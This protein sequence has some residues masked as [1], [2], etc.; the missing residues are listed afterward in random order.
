MAALTA[1][2]DFVIPADFA[3]GD[4]AAADAIRLLPEK[5]TRIIALNR[6]LTRLL[7][8]EEDSLVH[9]PHADRLQA[10]LP[11]LHTPEPE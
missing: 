11:D 5:T 1:M 9:A 2:M 7:A 10:P 6:L 3:W 8:A 4:S